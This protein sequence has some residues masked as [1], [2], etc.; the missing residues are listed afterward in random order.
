MSK[1]NNFNKW[2]NRFWLVYCVVI[3]I[4]TTVYSIPVSPL[5]I[6]LAFI[7]AVSDELTFRIEDLEKELEEIENDR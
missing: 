6:V 3:F 7:G 5:W 1:W 4:A 2:F